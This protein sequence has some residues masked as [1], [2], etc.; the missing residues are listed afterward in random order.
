MKVSSP[1]SLLL[2]ITYDTEK[3]LHFETPGADTLLHQ[4]G[5]DQKVPHLLLPGADAGAKEEVGNVVTSQI[6]EDIWFACWNIFNG[7]S[8]LWD[9]IQISKHHTTQ[10]FSSFSVYRIH[11]LSNHFFNK[12]CSCLA[13]LQDWFFLYFA[14]C[15]LK[16]SE[17]WQ[18]HKVRACYD[19]KK[20]I[21]HRR[22][23]TRAQLKY[24]NAVVSIHW[25]I[26]F[27]S[28]Y[29]LPQEAKKMARR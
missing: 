24:R 5:R 20:K 6:W 15:L 9:P 21:K 18:D 1:D 12:L 4:C 11:L 17:F 28:T 8:I 14:T 22:N 16:F 7:R 29:Y 25:E 27:P 19:R 23:C 10:K 13:L 26:I 2:W 3:A